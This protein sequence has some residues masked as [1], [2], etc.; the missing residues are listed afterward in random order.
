MVMSRSHV[1]KGGTTG[2]AF[3]VLEQQLNMSPL[4]FIFLM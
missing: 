2:E 3:Q 4:I 1:I